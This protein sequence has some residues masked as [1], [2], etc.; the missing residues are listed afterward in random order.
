MTS[1]LRQIL[2]LLLFFLFALENVVIGTLSTGNE[3]ITSQSQSHLHQEIH[4]LC[5]LF[6]EENEERDNKDGVVIAYGLSEIVNTSPN[7]YLALAS[8]M[9]RSNIEVRLFQKSLPLYTVYCS[10]II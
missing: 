3:T 6:A 7:H 2:T 1:R 9:I 5:P 4:P 8:G 10:F